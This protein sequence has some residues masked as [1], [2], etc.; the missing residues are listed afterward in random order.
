MIV[1][2]SNQ[3]HA[4]AKDTEIC[5]TLP[6]AMGLGGGYVPMIVTTN[7]DIQ[8]DQPERRICER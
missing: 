2:E 4:T 7:D 6:E 8:P 1:L 3:N 5:T